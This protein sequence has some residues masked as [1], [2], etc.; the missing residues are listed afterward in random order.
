MAAQLADMASDLAN[1][2]ESDELRRR[3]LGRMATIFGADV[4]LMA[5]WD[6]LAKAPGR[7]TTTA[8]GGETAGELRL[9]GLLKAMP[10]LTTLNQPQIVEHPPSEIG[11]LLESLL[12]VPLV[13]AGEL[14]GI[15]LLGTRRGG[16]RFG[17]VE[18]Q[19]ARLAG[20]FSAAVIGHAADF[21]RFSRDLRLQIV[22]ATQELTR[23]MSE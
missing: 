12:A 20:N 10:N 9:E 16:R 3:A 14:D 8:A 18:L 4:G 1:L 17:Q 21:E 7:I 23:L 22:E 6:K 13:A 2:A 15:L 19:M 5:P 11:L